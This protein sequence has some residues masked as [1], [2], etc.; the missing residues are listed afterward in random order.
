M[1]FIV[2]VALNQA[3]GPEPDE[4]LPAEQLPEK[5]GTKREAEEAGAARV[6]A[7]LQENGWQRGSV[8]YKVLDQHG[9]PV[10]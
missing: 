10:P 7:L 8:I 1:F 4:G 6:E 9:K 2:E 3:T 5:Y